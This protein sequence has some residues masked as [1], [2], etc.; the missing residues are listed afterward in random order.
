[1]ITIEE[2][3]KQ[4]QS[5]QLK[6][7]YFFFGEEDY[8]LEN[9]VHQ[10]IKKSVTPGLL[11]FNVFRFEGKN[12]DLERLSEAVEQY[13]QM[14]EKKV[15]WVKN[16][17]IF[18]NAAGREY[19]YIEKMIANLPDYTCLI[20]EETAFDKKK[21][22]NLRPVEENGAVAEFSYLPVNRVEIWLE[23]RFKKA[24][25]AI[26][27]RDLSYMVRLCGQSLRKITIE[28]E[29]LINY[30]GSRYKITREDI[31]AVVDQSVEYRVYDMLDSIL[32]E[33]PDKAQAQLKYL[34]DTNEAPTA[35][36]SIMMGK[37][38]ELLL[39]KLLHEEGMAPKDILPYFD[40]KR[41]MFVV[42]KTI[43]ESKRFGEKYLKRM[44]RLG[45][46]LDIKIKSGGMDGWTAAELYLAELT[47]RPE[48]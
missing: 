39:C 10:M 43:E 7:V 3:N 4:I 1:M 42:N 17:G 5:Q 45:L 20:F 18:Q 25:K 23:E 26:L 16:S 13:P 41:P 40:F 9:K 29:K 14:S 19:K 48:A 37:L 30:V 27:A 44:I 22:K 12:I 15:V 11:D 35:V 32:N 46:S 6:K 21:I 8:L 34:K 33:R 38:S 31:D 36:L 2:L 47:L 24:E 28:Y